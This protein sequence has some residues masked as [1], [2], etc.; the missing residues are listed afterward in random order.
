MPTTT[1]DAAVMRRRPK[2]SF[3]TSVPMT[4]PKI[5]LVSRSAVIGPS[6]RLLAAAR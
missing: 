5:T 4:A 6:G 1:I 3:R 2:P